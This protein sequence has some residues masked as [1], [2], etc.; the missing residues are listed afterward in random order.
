MRAA[1]KGLPRH[2]RLALSVALGMA[3][4]ASAQ[5]APADLTLEVVTDE[6]EAPIGV[7]A[8][9]D[10]SGR[11]F[12]MSQ[13][14]TIRIVKDGVLLPTPFLTVPVTYPGSGGTSGLLGLA[15][16]PNYG[17]DGLPHN[18][19]FYVVSMRP[20]GCTP[21]G[22]CLGSGPD[23]VLER[24]TVSANPDVANPTGTVVM[25]LADNSPPSF[26][27][28][29]DIHFGP[30]GY[31]YMSSGDGGQESGTHW[32]AECLWKKPNDTTSASCGTG[33]ATPQYFL[34][35]KMLRIDVD[36]RGAVAGPEM[37]GTATGVAA[38]YAIPPDNPYVGS[39]QTCD[40]IWLYGFRNPWRWSFDRAT[41][42]VWIGDVGQNQYEEIDLRAAGSN[43]PPY[44]GWHC[45]EGTAMFNSS[46]AC[47]PPIAP[48][49]LPL[50]EYTHAG[51]RCA[52]TG[53][54]RYRG[55]IGPLRGTYVYADSCSSEIFFAKPDA[56]GQW[57]STIWRDD[58][59]GYGTYSGFGEDEVGNLYVA[60]TATGVVYRFASSQVGDTHTVTP[61]AGPGGVL[62][63]ATPQVVDE[64]DTVAFDV[65]ADPGHAIDAVDGCGGVL[66]GTLYTTAPIVADCTVAATFAPD[67]SDIVFRDGFDAAPPSAPRGRITARAVPSARS[68]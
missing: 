66:A 3:G 22:T 7:R 61:Q 2:A 68:R 23:E 51:G 19:E 15:F 42:D 44:Y 52:V 65:Q 16:H 60:N 29:G 49:V 31:L 4:A 33:S 47:T 24:Y 59:N 45:M 37:C 11:L 55:P 20:P 21:A 8:P 40:E 25:R 32:L 9:H 46:Q 12:V 56:L 64:G 36:T 39:S 38:E 28:G 18:D 63:P 54:Y 41:G 27:N 10:G 26:H 30:D 43:D 62:S 1:R 6:V 17:R 67:A 53:G 5:T 14:G 48:N 58:A 34:R 13:A 35:G 57:S 50:L